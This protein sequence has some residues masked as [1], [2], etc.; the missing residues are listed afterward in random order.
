MQADIAAIDKNVVAEG[1]LLVVM[2]ALTGSDM[3]GTAALVKSS[4]HS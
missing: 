4:I 3:D 2:L 1:P